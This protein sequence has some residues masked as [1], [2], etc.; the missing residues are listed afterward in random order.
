VLERLDSDRCEALEADVTEEVD[1]RNAFEETAARFGGVDLVVAN[2][3]IAAAGSLE[4][5]DPDALRHAIDVNAV[6]VFH[7]LAEALRQFR[8]QDK[9]RLILSPGC[10]ISS[11]QMSLQTD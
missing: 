11:T 4:E 8:R 3:G 9:L 7:T 10:S 6:G 1:I 5:I 2:A